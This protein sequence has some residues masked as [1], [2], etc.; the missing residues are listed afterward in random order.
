MWRLAGWLAD[1]WVGQ[2]PVAATHKSFGFYAGFAPGLPVS[3][4]LKL[5]PMLA[6]IGSPGTI[7][8][9]TT[10]GRQAARQGGREGE[11]DE[12]EQRS[13][14]ACRGRPDTAWPA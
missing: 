1:W 10:D 4:Y 5:L 8:V 14:G 3:P 7:Q 9:G 2:D 6:G 11:D 12:G 13:M